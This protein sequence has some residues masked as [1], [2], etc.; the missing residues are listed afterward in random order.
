MQVSVAQEIFQIIWQ[1]GSVSL[2]EYSKAEQEIG[3]KSFFLLRKNSPTNIN[4]F[5]T[6]TALWLLFI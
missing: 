4:L 6:Y 5:F 2:N 3:H 1:I